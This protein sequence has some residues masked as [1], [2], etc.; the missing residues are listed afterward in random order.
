NLAV[1]EARLGDRGGALALLSG[2]LDGLRR[3]TRSLHAEAPRAARAAAS[4]E[5]RHLFEVLDVGFHL[6]DE[7]VLCPEVFATLEGLRAVSVAGGEITRALAGHPEL[8]ERRD[9]IGQARGRLN[10]LVA[11]GPGAGEDV[12]QWRSAIQQTAAERDRLE[13]ELFAGLAQAG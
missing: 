11:R 13:H 5:F 1:I 10:D 9:A 4:F 6:G 8:A 12:E 2:Y 7:S 3:H